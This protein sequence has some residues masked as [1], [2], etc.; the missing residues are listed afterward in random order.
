M[1]SP[2]RKRKKTTEDSF[3]PLQ[4]ISPLH[5]ANRQV[6]IYLEK[7]IDDLGL[8]APE[9]HL[10]SYVQNYGP[11]PVGELVNVLGHKKST[12]TNMLD[13]M[14]EYGYLR[15]EVNPQD[16]RSFLIATTRSGTRIGSATR[17]RVL[18]AE[19]D[20]LQHLTA[21]DLKAFSKV[22]AAIDEVTG[23]EIRHSSRDKG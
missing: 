17:D 18:Q 7:L 4:V 15:R 3:Q 11:C 9:A 14:E 12:M 16:R 1:N 22:I 2:K 20:I 23:V 8:T 21:R 19:N 10:L 13:R 6:A 5:R